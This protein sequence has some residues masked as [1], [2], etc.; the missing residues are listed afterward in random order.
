VSGEGARPVRRRFAEGTTVHDLKAYMEPFAATLGYKLNTD[1][2]FVDAVLTSELAI[3]EATGDVYC[4]CRIRT[5]D[6]KEDVHIVCPCIPF[7][8]QQFA[9]IRKCWCGLF[10]RTDV[11]DGAELLGVVDEPEP[12]TSIE[13]P[14]CRVSDLAPGHVRHVKLGKDDIVLARVADEFFAL[15]NVCRHAFA[16]LSDGVLEGYELMCP[17]HGWRYDVRDGSTDHPNADVKTYP[18]TVRDDLLFIS[19]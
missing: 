1:V 5:G 6:P 9:A 11:D 10:I 18:V 3:L 14:V 16:P 15:S 2:D 13:V 8:M 17:W 4:P 12:G 19:V 7:H